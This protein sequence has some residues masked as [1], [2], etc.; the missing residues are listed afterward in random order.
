MKL[1]D[2]LSPMGIRTCNLI[3]D[4]QTPYG[5]YRHQP[6]QIVGTQEQ[7]SPD[8]VINAIKDWLPSGCALC[9]LAEIAG[10]WTMEELERIGDGLVRPMPPYRYL[11]VDRSKVGGGTGD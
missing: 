7:L 10:D 1:Q 11:Y 8:A 3:V 4:Y 9:S 2:L 5:Q 6:H